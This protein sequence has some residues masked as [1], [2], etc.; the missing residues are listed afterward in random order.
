MWPGLQLKTDLDCLFEGGAEPVA[1]DYGFEE[2]LGFDVVGLAVASAYDGYDGSLAL[3]V[4]FCIGTFWLG[5]FLPFTLGATFG[6]GLSFDLGFPI[7][8]EGFSLEIFLCSFIIV[9]A[10]SLHLLSKSSLMLFKKL[11]DVLR[12][13]IKTNLRSKL[14]NLPKCGI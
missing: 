4:T 1:G 9:Y 8:G 2:E 10:N 7:P 13:T 12:Q 3:S 11:L 6:G 14:G 5:A